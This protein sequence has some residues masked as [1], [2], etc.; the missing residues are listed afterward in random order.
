[1][2]RSIEDL[3]NDVTFTVFDCRI[4]LMNLSFWVFQ[5]E[6]LATS[7]PRLT[8][9]DHFIRTSNPVARSPLSSF[10]LVTRP[11]EQYPATVFSLTF[12]GHLQ[13]NRLPTELVC[14]TQ[15][16]LHHRTFDALSQLPSGHLSITIEDGTWYI[17]ALACPLGWNITEMHPSNS[18]QYSYPAALPFPSLLTSSI[19]SSVNAQ[20][21]TLNEIL[22]LRC[23]NIRPGERSTVELHAERPPSTCALSS[24]N[25]IVSVWF[26]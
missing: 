9:Q 17:G 20:V 5:L 19:L 11:E 3:E 16:A 7:K 2:P 12:R 21:G 6:E 13:C 14:N 24:T 8:A 22:Q 18:S 15:E 10:P 1:M 26:S 25:V 4:T 23:P